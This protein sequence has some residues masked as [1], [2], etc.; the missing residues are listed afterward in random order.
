MKKYLIT[1]F[2]MIYCV[3]LNAQDYQFINE[4]ILPYKE[5]NYK[6]NNAI[7]LDSIY[8]MKK[9]IIIGKDF[10][11]IEYFN[12]KS[13]KFWWNDNR[14]SPLVELFL[15]NFNFEHLKADLIRSKNDSIIDFTKLNKYFHSTDENYQNEYPKN[16]YLSI[17]KPFFNC[18]RDWCFIIKSKY[19]PYVQAGGNGQMFIYIKINGKWILYNRVDLWLS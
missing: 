14:N 19:I 16:Q 13:I 7:S 8:L 9:F 4:V 6:D 5:T 3:G 15:K 11:K 18:N 2:I 10:S 1:L 12:E 17:S